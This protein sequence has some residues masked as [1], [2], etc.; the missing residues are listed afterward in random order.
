MYTTGLKEHDTE[1]IN[2]QKEKK[3]SQKTDFQKAFWR[4]IVLNFM[5]PYCSFWLF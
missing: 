5:K 4:M 2:Q 3:P 1:I